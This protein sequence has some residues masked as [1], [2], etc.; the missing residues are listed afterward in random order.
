MMTQFEKNHN[1][2]QMEKLLNEYQKE[3]G[4]DGAL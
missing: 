3:Y 1:K 2:D 4:G